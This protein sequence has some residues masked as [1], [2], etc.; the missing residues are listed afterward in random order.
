MND[1]AKY[2]PFDKL[3][4]L[5]NEKLAQMI[6]VLEGE[7]P[8]IDRSELPCRYTAERFKAYYPE[9]YKTAV[10]LLATGRFS[11]AEIAKFVHADYR[12]IRQVAIRCV[13]DVEAAREMVQQQALGIMVALGERTME[14][15]EKAQK[16]AES[17]IPMGIA[18][19]IYLQM[20]GLPTARVE[21]DHKIDCGAELAELLRKAEEK[22]AKAHVVESSQLPN[23]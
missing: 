6:L 10:D 14:L 2:V 17:M 20:G 21:I 3:P 4:E 7:E 13:K 12:T 22:V 9:R 16:P 18:K 23:E 15:I 11:E 19:D 5:P 8:A 1:I